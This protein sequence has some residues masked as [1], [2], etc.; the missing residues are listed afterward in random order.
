M[1][2]I[3]DQHDAATVPVVEVH[4]FDWSTV[5]LLVTRDRRQAL[6]DVPPKAC[7]SLAK[8]CK[9]TWHR[10]M[11]AWHPDGPKHIGWSI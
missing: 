8:A 6:L 3:S 9:A 2:S 5:D 10:V 1:G 11:G 7:K 4:L